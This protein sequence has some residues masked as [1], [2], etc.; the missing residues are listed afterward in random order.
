MHQIGR[1]QKDC[2]QMDARTAL[3]NKVIIFNC[4]AE[5]NPTGT[6]HSGLR[7]ADAGSC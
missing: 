4:A 2:A 3:E 5:T 6:N 1:A 7:S